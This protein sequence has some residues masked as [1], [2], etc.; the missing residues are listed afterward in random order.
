M[1]TNN[2]DMR[3]RG[4]YK[5]PNHKSITLYGV[6]LLTI[7]LAA[8]AMAITPG[9]A[10]CAPVD[11][12]NPSFETNVPEDGGWIQ[13]EIV[14]EWYEGSIDGWNIIGGAGNLRPTAATFPD[15]A[16]G[17]VNVAY[18]HGDGGISQLLSHTVEA[19]YAYTLSVF[20]GNR[21]T[22][23]DINEYNVQLLAGGIILAE[24]RNLL[25]PSEGTFVLSTISFQARTGD[26]SI[27]QALEIRLSHTGTGQVSFDQVVM[28]ISPLDID[29]G[30]VAHY[31]FNYNANDLSPYANHGIPHGDIALVAD[32]FG[33]ENSAY[34]FDG[35]NDYINLGH[36]TQ[37]NFPGRSH[38]TFS[39]WVKFNE[40][41]L[42]L[43]K[44]NSVIA[45]QYQ[46]SV[47]E[48]N[49][50]SLLREVWPFSVQGTTRLLAGTWY[51]FCASYDGSSMRLY[52]NGNEEIRQDS[53]TV[54]DIANG[55]DVFIGARLNRGVVDSF[56][57]GAIDDLRIYNRSLTGPEIETL[58]SYEGGANE[59]G[60]TLDVGLTAYYPFNGNAN[61][62]ST[63]ANHG[64]PLGDIELVADR[65]GNENSAYGF[66]GVDDYIN[67][68]HP[69][70]LNFPGRSPFTFSAW[71]RFNQPGLIINKFNRVIAGQYQFFINEDRFLSL[72]REV[73]PW[74]VNGATSLAPETWYYL[75][76]S[77]D[78]LTMRVYVNGN[79]E[80]RQD[81]GAVADIGNSTDVFI[82]AGLNVGSV[83]SFFNG[84]IDELR[85]YNRALTAPEIL[86][87]YNYT[88]NSFED[89]QAP[90][91]QIVAGPESG[92]EIITD[93][94]TFGWSATDNMQ[95]GLTYATK[96]D[97]SPWSGFTA[98]TSVILYDL[99]DGPHIFSV[100][101]K[102]FAGN[103][104]T[105]PAQRT[106]HVSA[107]PH[108]V[109]NLS[110][111]SFAARLVFSWT[112]PVNTVGDLA[113]YRV[114]FNESSSPVS[115]APDSTRWEVTGLDP[116]TSYGFR[117]TAVDNSAHESPGAS[118]IGATLLP[119]PNNLSVTPYSGYVSLSW[120]EV[121]PANLVKHYAVYLSAVEFA[122]VE[123]MTPVSTATNTN[124]SVAGLTDNTTYFVAVTAVNLS[125]GE[126]KHV[127]AVSAIPIPDTVGPQLDNI[128][129]NGQP[130]QNGL[131]LNN[132]AIIGLNASD[133]AGVGRVEFHI[134][135]QLAGT[136]SNGAD[137]YGFSWNIQAYA[138]E[139][140][141]LAITA[142][143][144][145]GN[146]TSRH[147]SLMVALNAPSMAP[148]ILQPVNHALFN[149]T[150]IIVKGSAAPWTEV[151]LYIN[152]ALIDSWSPVDAKGNFS[153]A[154]TLSEGENRI[155]A[156]ARNRG[157]VG[158]LSNEVVV[159]LDTDIPQAPMHLA[160]L[161]KSG[162]TIAL[163][164]QRP[165]EASFR[166]FNLYR[167]ATAF[168]APGQAQRVNV[169]PLAA[170]A[171]NDLP[172]QDGVYYYGVTTVDH[173]NNE[174]ALSN[175][176]SASSDRM[177]PR[178]VSIQYAPTGAFDLVSGRTGPGLVNVAV[179]VSEPLA[180]A[181]HLSINPE[182]AVPLTVDLR[183]ASDNSYT[184]FFIIAE[185]TPTGTAYAV[186]SGR[187]AAGNRGTEIQGGQSIAIDT[188]GP[189]VGAILVQPASPIRNDQDTP[190]TVQVTISLDEAMAQGEM[191]SLAF[192][193]SGEGRGSTAIE[194]LALVTSP[195]GFAQSWIA[196]FTLPANAGLTQPESLQFIFQG[197]D[198]LGNIG[199][200]FA[201]ANLFQVY[202]GDLP[203]LEAPLNLSGASLS[204]G[205]IRLTWSAV[206]D[207]DGYQLYRQAPGDSQ[208]TAFQRFESETEFIDTPTAEGYHSYAVS[209]IR[210]ENG[211]EAVSGMSNTVSV[212]SDAEAPVAPQNLSLELA[213]Q[214]IFA[215]W[216]DDANTET[217]T[218]ALYRSA[219]AQI[220]TVEGLTP[221]IEN[222]PVHSV[223]D[224]HPSPT[225]HAY[226][227]T[228]IDAAG[229]QSA[230]SA[231]VY[232][233]FQLLPVASLS[234]RQ[235]DSQP[236]V[237]A[238]TH[239]AGDIAG[240]DIYL[241]DTKLNTD[242][243][244]GTAYTDI[245]YDGADRRYSV[246]A[247]DQNGARS[248]NREILLPM[249][250]ATLAPEQTVRRGLM[251]QVIFDVTNGSS[252]QI[253]D[254]R[255]GVD[256][257]GH[258][259][260]TEAF[261]M[262]P[263]ESRQVPVVIGGHA[264]LPDP[265]SATLTLRIAPNPGE[266]VEIERQEQ[267]RV[268]DGMMTLDI[269]NQELLRGAGGRIQFTLANSGGGEV[270][271]VTARGNGALASNEIKIY[272]EDLDGNVLSTAAFK[273]NI[274]EG[275][276]T[277][278]NGT[279][280]ARIP[281]GAIFTSAEQQIPIPPNAPEA[282]VIRLAIA[283]V[284][285]H[286][287]REDH[288][289][290]E[291]L[292]TTRQLSMVETAYYG[293]VFS[294]SPQN[295][296]SGDDIVIGGR[297]VA[298]AGG[299]PMAGAPLKLVIANK[300][301]ER[302]YEVIAD[303]E[304]HF[305]YTF[306]PMAGESGLYQVWAVHPDLS[307]KPVQA[308]FS[309]NRLALTPT[310]INLSIP[311][312]YE[313]SVNVR[314]TAGEGTTV[315]NLRLAY[316]PLDQPAG[317]YP[318]GV[319]VSLGNAVATLGPGASANLG[320]KIWADNGAAASSR[321]VLKVL[322]DDLADED[323]GRIVVNAAFTQ[324]T[325]FLGVTPSFIETGTA[326][327][328]AVTENILLQNK[329]AADLEAVTLALLDPQ[330]NPAPSWVSLLNA[331]ELGDLAVGATRQVSVRFAPPA[332]QVAEGNY[333][334]NLRVR[335]A[336]YPE[337]AIPVFVAVTQSGAGGVLFKVADIYTGTMD[338]ASG[339][340]IQGLRGARVELQ[341]EQVL[342]VTTSANTDS[343]GEALFNDLPVGNYKCRVTAGNHQEHIGRLWI[344]PGV[345][346]LQEV[347]LGSNLVTVDWSVTETTIQD[348]YNLV[349][350]PTYETD[351]PA[352]MVVAE[353]A[354]VNLPEMQ[355][356]DVFHGEFNLT[357]YGL[358]RA[359]ELR[360]ALPPDNANYKYELIDGLPDS[361]E[362]KQRI[363]VPYRVTCIRSTNQDDPQGSGGGSEPCY[364]AIGISYRFNCEYV[365]ADGTRR[366]QN[367][368][369]SFAIVTSGCTSPASPGGGG[370]SSITVNVNDNRNPQAVQLKGSVCYPT[371]MR[372]ERFYGDGGHETIFQS[373]DDTYQD[374]EQDTGCSVNCVLREY[375]DRAED[376]YVKVPG[377][378]IAADRRY[379]GKQWYWNHQLSALD[380]VVDPITS[381]VTGIIKG[382]VAYVLAA[383][384]VTTERVYV[385]DTYKIIASPS[386]YRWEDKD[387][388]W[389]V[390]DPNGRLMSH[391]AR[392]G[393]IANYLYAEG[394]ARLMG[395]ADKNGRQVLWYEY[396][397]DGQIQRIRDLDN[398]VV[399]YGYENGRLT[400]VTDLSG[401][402]TQYQYDGQGRMLQTIDAA[403]RPT[404]VAYDGY[405]N[406]SQV[407]DS[408]GRGH[409]FEYYYDE[410]SRE[411]Y[412]RIRTSSGRI[413]EVWY[414]GEG[415]TRRVDINGRTIK[416]MDKDRRNLIVTDEKGNVTHKIFDEWQNLTRVI[417][418]DGSTVAIDYDLR[419]NK[420]SRITNPL[421]VL[422]LFEYDDRGN[423]V[424]MTRAA[425]TGAE[426]VISY[427]YNAEGRPLTATVAADAGT[428]EAAIALSY[429]GDGNLSR[430]IDPEGN[431]FDFMAYDGMGNLLELRDARRNTWRFGYDPAGRMISQTDPLGHTTR[432]EYDGVN[433]RT[434]LIDGLLKR[435]EFE[436]DDHNNRVRTTDPTLHHITADYNSDGLPTSIVDQEGNQQQAA[437]DNEG[438]ALRRI[439][440][441][442]NTTSFV[443][444]DSNATFASSAKP[445]R[446]E[447]PTFVRHLYYD[448]MQRVVRSVDEMDGTTRYERRY[449]YDAAGNLTAM[450]D[451]QGRTTRFQ[452]D[453]LDRLTATVDA[454]GGVA[455]RA[456]D[457]RNN[458]IR[459]QDANNAT[460]RYEYDRSNRLVRMVRP[461]GEATRYEYDPNGNRTA[462]YDAKGQRIDY[463]YDAA[464]RQV[465]TR[466][467]AAGNAGDPIRTVH[468]QYD[469]VGNLTAYD[470]G[471]T[472]GAYVYDDLR[473]KIGETVDYGSFSLNYGYTYYANGLKRS[474]TGPDG[475]TYGYTYDRNNRLARIDNPGT[476]PVS[477]NA[478]EW[479]SL[480][481]MTLPGG[482]AQEFDYD[483]LRR[484][485]A[486][487]AYDPGR[488]PVLARSYTHAP[489][490][491]ILTAVTEQGTHSYQYDALQRLV[492]ADH[493]SLP[494]EGYT[495]DPTGNRLSSNG[496]EGAWQYNANNELASYGG[497]SFGY[498]ANGN[499]IQR[500]GTGA[501]A[502]FTYDVADR[503]TGVSE[504]G[505]ATA[506]Y[507]YDPFGRRL[508]KEVGGT[509]TYFF[510]TDEG[511]VAEYDQ[512][513]TQLK[514]YGYK[515][516]ALWGTDPLFQKVG[517][518]YYWYLND[519]L[520]T[521]QRM[522]D[523]SGR[524][525]WAAT[526][527]SFG[528]ARIDTAEVAN[529]LRLP[530]QYFD[531]ETGLHYNWYRYYSPQTGRYLQT[532]PLMD[533]LNLYSY[534]RSRPLMYIDP[535]GLC[536]SDIVHGFLDWGSTFD[537]LFFADAANVALYFY[538]GD[539]LNAWASVGSVFLPSI[540]GRLSKMVADFL[541]KFFDDVVEAGSKN[542][543]NAVIGKPRVGSANKLPDGQHGFNDII[544]NYAGDAAKFDVPTKGP[545]G[546]V[547]RTSELRQIEGSN[548]GVDGV[549]EW[550]VDKGNV[551]HRR[552]I[553][554]GKVTGYPNQVPK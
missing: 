162:G 242:L 323:W 103:E 353:P 285:H 165:M 59:P 500:S 4:A 221:I 254:I 135:G 396:T 49:Y 16:P 184:G 542:I 87:L 39:A 415:K 368:G 209:S 113:G 290:M 329:G 72:H 311:K 266:S 28:D 481:R 345:T 81:S 126:D 468:F 382:A 431:T 546:K 336:N 548:N 307:D 61:D 312:N 433:N 212:R 247:V 289:V 437:Y 60:S 112:P 67:L 540:L 206:P 132:T 301:F 13:N 445:V 119:N 104:E 450:T 420:P 381:Q 442:G 399:A 462:L 198:D 94:V 515:P 164:W 217:V 439:D 117:I 538:E 29:S 269:L 300:G 133:P 317:A 407:T 388:N 550:I 2:A 191:P 137:G 129:L 6:K 23:Y 498:D 322:S 361:L 89:I 172:A 146:S 121:L 438:R 493:P 167:A 340:V 65:F 278:A 318:V 37:L 40:P 342:T 250:R 277:L 177:P 200:Q 521:P 219:Q 249:L 377:G 537:P 474:Y 288:V 443:Y 224:T 173:A 56:F 207:A 398:R 426:Q 491:D 357:N 251:N 503:L 534:V 455:T 182:G 507:D 453:A 233:N 516:D 392:Q 344:K 375:N 1:N 80:N 533:G 275:I 3:I 108:D 98:K 434:A 213:P 520:G 47:N 70:Q 380:L 116:A 35:V 105:D 466:Y 535:Y 82:G 454:T 93:S 416:K 118:I 359:N 234:V 308:Q 492:S 362:A 43:N 293:E 523:G 299:Q 424:R 20:I 408:Q 338:Q 313:Q 101:A 181:P 260:T 171:Y 287:G 306:V 159:T 314:V 461:M 131:I 166:G 544:D 460:T 543:D 248:L 327:D 522:I 256:V 5:A 410:P 531:A 188:K 64:A 384:N 100:R 48:N 528:N 123:G 210:R 483:P 27:G 351:V 84:A 463:V 477:F 42:I 115:L 142:Y 400:D 236:P 228:A 149:G 88:E 401:N 451:E 263:G 22:D 174:S 471:T 386:G 190:V 141:A 446:I 73:T 448:T 480:K 441:A 436:Y 58:Y 449:A 258:A 475:L 332:A 68:G 185:T 303:G 387:G 539:D 235:G 75:C 551:T 157:G 203:P 325:A 488:N 252:Q 495:Y 331:S 369:A 53:G 36:P 447:Y 465:E 527:D 334:F 183:R 259:S 422:T 127:A 514:S 509:R 485:R 32:R 74:K 305:A 71:V 128:Q 31:P 279:S 201:C 239:A 467:Y 244:T 435:Y 225:Q 62:F 136:D 339:Q 232:L 341:N 532:D 30:L 21:N 195:Q 140:H 444:D 379:F 297:A 161:A 352:A 138:D 360:F 268:A 501:G 505:T 52:V 79:E 456:Y 552:F 284:H 484:L 513:G 281:A 403:G 199:D 355:A 430:I 237:V 427:T 490:D 102:D 464:N 365:Q 519:H 356:G 151:A 295:A 134:D 326:L 363:T 270:E 25:S 458:L 476:G 409:F 176:A 412:A 472:S 85:I 547:V 90:V 231:S 246:V 512:N 296:F 218:Y 214:G 10:H 364:S 76:A 230:P 122:T 366:Q 97:D 91:T 394:N 496:V 9:A 186:F 271:I 192:L 517:A 354:S 125:D 286:L 478:Y 473:R 26:S 510:Y 343:A 419:F 383:A 187:D 144:T 502:T 66:D 38:F 11:I 457:D 414:D 160:A 459:I 34:G 120:S 541:G 14:G 487:Q 370:T 486:I 44:Y 124:C 216:E 499:M 405:G 376:I 150:D 432:Y 83:G 163:T 194:S 179:T 310:T 506:S 204:G 267:I 45:G 452:Y 169:Q 158:P 529:N 350:T 241:N 328:D 504:N 257:A 315:Q 57:N 330:G 168:S 469:A 309:I 86:L 273:Q 107:A 347:F 154:L 245:G 525:V 178:A 371:G 170:A 530:G 77:Y 130:M 7:L 197:E 470:D 46:F 346:G 545:G 324:A 411:Y 253:R 99:A 238:W 92:S 106:F 265:A 180:M 425:G 155:R 255:L 391:G 494:D 511:L 41:G 226:V 390:Y 479:N 402:P 349:L 19:G 143:D 337:R 55:T 264:D 429:D 319:H 536:V 406:V 518:T 358:I 417:H 96:L 348:K 428:A 554:G 374:I 378:R 51:H 205:R 18:V 274:G 8:V 294:V 156:A 15:G 139:S 280:V 54:S 291:G 389:K 50:L 335:S 423:L 320:F 367:G 395:V 497:N 114:Y 261:T 95:W 404:H 526:Y 397:A 189:T 196:T 421:G 553:P 373:G 63:Y 316:E 69:P 109:T 272:L 549:F 418:P 489:N 193:L 215:T 240:F 276:V 211:Q 292:G 262:A 508:W 393:T 333:Q 202:Q 175:V 302:Q 440:G 153:L 208:L 385:H 372:V 229:N 524:V 111:E 148:A 482:A 227:V 304:G 24:D 321:L 12:N 145:L 33:N 222:I 283:N 223:V 78:G 413:K 243:L 220:S 282:V 17:G 298:R 147:Y 110:V 152:S